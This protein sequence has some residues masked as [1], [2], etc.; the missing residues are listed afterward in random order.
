MIQIDDR[1]IMFPWRSA[2]ANNC[3]CYLIDGPKRVLIDPGHTHLF[4][5]V[6]SGLSYLDLAID[7]IDVV[8][9]THAHPDHIESVQL[10]R[11]APTLVAIHEAEW[12]F[13]QSVDRYIQASFGVGADAMAPDIFLCNGTF[14]IGDTDLTIIHTP[15][16]SPGSMSIFWPETGALFTGDVIF[17]EGL[18]R[19]DLPGGNGDRLKESI[20]TLS[21]MDA[22]CLLP[23]HGDIVEGSEAVASNFDNVENYW[24]AYI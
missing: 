8:L 1:L 12:Q 6:R 13:I 5:H 21:S 16:H 4:D 24:F 11:E 22:R 7:D 14:S 15:G 3:N 2:N 19:T 20:R 10:F 23:G 18:G 17:R 9:C